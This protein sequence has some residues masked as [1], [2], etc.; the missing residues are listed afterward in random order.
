MPNGLGGEPGSLSV[1]ALRQASAVTT[2]MMAISAM[3]M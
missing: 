1:P 3:S 2:A